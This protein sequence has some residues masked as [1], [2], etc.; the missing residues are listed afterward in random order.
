MGLPDMSAE[1]MDQMKVPETPNANAR[2]MSPQFTV[3]YVTIKSDCFVGSP[4]WGTL[5]RTP[6]SRST[7]TRSYSRLAETSYFRLFHLGPDQM[8]SKE[9]LEAP[10]KQIDEKYK[11]SKCFVI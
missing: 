10:M 2:S 5:G 11:V 7:W 4:Y 6:I 9:V 1:E 8:M 3:E